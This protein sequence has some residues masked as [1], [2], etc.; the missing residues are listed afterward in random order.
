MGYSIWICERCGNP[1]HSQEYSSDE[2][3]LP[4]RGIEEWCGQSDGN[5]EGERRLGKGIGSGESDAVRKGRASGSLG[6][7]YEAETILRSSLA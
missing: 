7:V 6:G 5:A 1:P 4:R 3:E 2:A